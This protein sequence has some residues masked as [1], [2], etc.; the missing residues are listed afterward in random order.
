MP[1]PLVFE[2]FHLRYVNPITNLIMYDTYSQNTTIFSM[3]SIIGT[4]LHVSAL[5]IG[6][7]QVDLKL[8]KQLY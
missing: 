4:Q 2:V 1:C 8:V 5:S 3:S 7:H 6:H